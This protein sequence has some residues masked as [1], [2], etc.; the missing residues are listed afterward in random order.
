[1]D[2]A[3]RALEVN[4][5]DGDFYAPGETTP[6]SHGVVLVEGDWKLSSTGSAGI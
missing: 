2:Q 1:L 5:V 4:V 6:A 3:E